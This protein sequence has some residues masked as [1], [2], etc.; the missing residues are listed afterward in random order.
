MSA[1]VEFTGAIDPTIDQRRHGAGLALGRGARARDRRAASRCR[2]TARSCTID[3]PRTGWQ[4]GDRY[5]ALV[6]GGSKG[7][8][9]LAGEKVECDAAFY[10]LRQHEALD[11]PDHEHAFPGDDH[12]ERVSNASRAREAS[13]RISTARSTTSPAHDM[14]RDDVAALWAFTVTTRTELAMDQPSQRIPLPID[15][16]D[17]S[18]D[19]PR[20]CADRAVGQ[21]GRGRSEGPAVG[22][23]RRFAVGQPA[24]RVHRADEPG[25]DHRDDRPALPARR[26]TPVL[27]A[28]DGRA[29]RR[30]DA[31][32]RHAEV[33]PACRRRRRTRSCSAKTIQDAAGQTPAIMPIGHFLRAH[34]PVLVDGTSQIRAIDDHDALKVENSRTELAPRSTRSAATTS[35]PRG[36]S[37]R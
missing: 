5:V 31:P 18:G 21:R 33:G 28:G 35:S 27:D 34:A 7:L 6:R 26:G 24:V 23:R 11:T 37:R 8:V 30:Q 36:R 17:R 14:P 15:L 10:F 12:D 9:G 29:A 19:R 1:T 16:D 20:R 32:R 22:A 2:P 25:D 4:R 3:P 13:A